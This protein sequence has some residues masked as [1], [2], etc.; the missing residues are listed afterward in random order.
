MSTHIADTGS[1]V[2]HYNR[3]INITYKEE[4]L[5]HLNIFQM[6]DLPNAS[7]FMA[8]FPYLFQMNLHSLC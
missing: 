3:G 4:I 8:S 7:E 6:E 5:K 1:D 2:S